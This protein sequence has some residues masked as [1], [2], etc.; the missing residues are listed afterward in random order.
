MNKNLVNVIHPSGRILSNFFHNSKRFSRQISRQIFVSA[1]DRLQ[2]LFEPAYDNSFPLILFLY[3]RTD[4]HLQ[5]S[6][7]K[8]GMKKARQCLAENSSGAATR[9][10]TRDLLITSQLLYQLS[11]SGIKCRGYS[12]DFSGFGLVSIFEKFFSTNWSMQHVGALPF[13]RS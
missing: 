1:H 10:R 9:L 4:I 7:R 12:I 11:Y 6:T 5:S 8:I 13:C 3:I 2:W